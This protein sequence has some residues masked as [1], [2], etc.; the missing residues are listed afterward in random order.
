MKQHNVVDENTVD[1]KETKIIKM[2][3]KETKSLLPKKHVT[4]REV[5]RVRI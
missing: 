2:N 3:A 1:A 5:K 4:E